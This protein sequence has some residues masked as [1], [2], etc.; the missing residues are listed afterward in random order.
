MAL[1]G[2]GAGKI[3][4]CL[5]TLPQRN[6]STPHP[7]ARLQQGQH[8]SSGLRRRPDDSAGK[9]RQALLK[10][11]SDRHLQRTEGVE[12]RAQSGSATL[13]THL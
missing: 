4:N 3:K 5:Q 11:S 10:S 2:H 12:S 9:G 6:T 13:E 7:G 8:S 1:E